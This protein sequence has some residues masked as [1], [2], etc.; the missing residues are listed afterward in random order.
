[1]DGVQA[2][3]QE[4]AGIIGHRKE[5][6]GLRAVAVLSV[7]FCHAGFSAFAGGFVGVDVFFVIS[8]YLITSII[9]RELAAGT[10]SLRRFYERR[11]RRIL[12]ALFVVLAV[13]LPL[14]WLWLWPSDFRDFAKSLVYVVLFASNI[15]FFKEIG[16]FEPDVELRPMLHTWS[17]GVEEQYYI[18]FPLLLLLAWRLGARRLLMPLAILLLASLGAAQYGLSRFPEAT[19]YLLPTRAWELLVGAVYAVLVAQR[20]PLSEIS[21]RWQNLV[22]TAGL[23]MILTAVFL[24]SPR[25]PFP[26]LAALLPTLGA[27]LVIATATPDTLVGRLLAWRPVLFVGLW[28]YSIYLWHQP[29]FAF[30]RYHLESPGL[31]LMAGLACLTLGLGYLS[32]RYVEGPLRKPEWQG[33]RLLGF[34]VAGIAFFLVV[35]LIGKHRGDFFKRFAPDY[36]MQIGVERKLGKNYGLNAECDTPHAGHSCQTA[37]HPEILL[38]GDSY[39]MHLADGILASHPDVSLIQRTENNC[40]ALL[41]IAPIV[42][43]NIQEAKSCMDFNAAVLNVLEG[44]PTIRVVVLGGL[45]FQYL[46]EGNA[47][48]TDDGRVVPAEGPLLLQELRATLRRLGELGVSVVLVAPPPANGIDIGKCL[49]RSVLI[50][51]SLEHCDFTLDEM[52]Q[53][54]RQVYQLLSALASETRIIWLHQLM[55]P[56]GRC[57]T[58]DGDTF[59]F[60]DDGHLSREGANLLGQKHDF[61]RLITGNNELTTQE[62]P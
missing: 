11:A 14:A 60:I 31:P 17:L 8:G 56:D 19:F 32:W 22:S 1:M 40:A 12:P 50:G 52:S 23:G 48:L 25:T 49:A 36:A 61:Y 2:A 59:L 55:C 58:H 16:Y 47:I 18:L 33:K 46:K 57:A 24:Y 27:L 29:L 10:F 54:R 28:S 53:G 20:H 6:D 43:G 15:H 7:V 35:G 62:K 21:S 13:C 4:R 37:A 5:I 42:A 34:A 41:G 3:T 30:A 45:Y 26:G 9:L 38:W 39:A 44:T 51:R